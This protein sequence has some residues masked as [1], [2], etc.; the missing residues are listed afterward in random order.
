[1][2]N[3]VIMGRKTWESIPLRFRPLTNRLNV[4]VTRGPEDRISR[5]AT[6][7]SSELKQR[8][9]SVSMCYDEQLQCNKLTSPKHDPV[10]VV[11]SIEKGLRALQL[12]DNTPDS[13]YQVDKIFV[14]GGAQI[15]QSLL[16]MDPVS[17]KNEVR[18]KTGAEEDPPAFGPVRILQTQVR[19]RDGEA[20]DCDTFFPLHLTLREKSHEA[21][22][23]SSLQF[24][25][26][27]KWK[28]ASSS[29]IQ[30]WLVRGVVIPSGRDNECW[31]VDGKDSDMEIRMVGWERR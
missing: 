15:Y 20:I 9:E 7:I 29:E 14:I 22:Q 13:G 11:S 26:T 8:H 28:P 6:S 5:T 19:R 27:Q 2:R 4:V 16:E 25:G 24:Q 3:A 23:N 1:M 31:T 17:S 10:F 30:Q 12:C 21:Q 18:P